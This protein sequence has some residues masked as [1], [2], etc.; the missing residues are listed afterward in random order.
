MQNYPQYSEKILKIKNYAV[1]KTFTS[2]KGRGQVSLPGLAWQV[3]L[4][5]Y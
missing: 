5:N 2:V 4:R 3:G 1:L